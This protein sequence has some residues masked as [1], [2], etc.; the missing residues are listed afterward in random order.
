MPL[1][2][3]EVGGGEQRV[4]RSDHLISG[5]NNNR[6]KDMCDFKGSGGTIQIQNI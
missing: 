2:G 4:S 3:G 5:N 1:E 6:V